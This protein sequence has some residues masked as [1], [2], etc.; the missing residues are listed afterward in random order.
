VTHPSK[1][2][3]Y[4]AAEKG[5]FTDA[6]MSLRRLVANQRSGILVEKI[7][8]AAT[9]LARWHVIVIGTRRM[10]KILHSPQATTSNRNQQLFMIQDAPKMMKS[11]KILTTA[12]VFAIGTTGFTMTASAAGPNRANQPTFSEVDKDNDG[13]ITIA[14]IQAER[15]AR[16]S[17][18]DTDGDALLSSAE[19]AAQIVKTS[20]LR[21]ARIA[22]R[23][24]SAL[25]TNDDGMLSKVEAAARGPSAA[26][27]MQKLDQDGDG[28]LSED[29]FTQAD[30][31]RGHRPRA[32]N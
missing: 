27:M 23:M 3:A 29:E 14:E 21:A 16:F 31:R 15:A 5:P 4:S 1:N 17:A 7:A 13:Q 9:E 11:G 25:D 2:A 28:I 19:V 18:T 24:L 26:R 20:T 6:R 8:T 22:D 32:T 12:L 30:R 10:N